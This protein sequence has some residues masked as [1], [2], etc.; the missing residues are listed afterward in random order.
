MPWSS[1]VNE[2]DLR[3]E[4]LGTDGEQSSLDIAILGGLLQFDVKAK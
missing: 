3:N 2:K 1:L 4:A